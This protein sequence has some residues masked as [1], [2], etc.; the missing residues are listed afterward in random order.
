MYL[1]G[2]YSLVPMALLDSADRQGK[3][4]SLSR[5]EGKFENVTVGVILKLDR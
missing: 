2:W 4:H 5:K 3:T 1:L